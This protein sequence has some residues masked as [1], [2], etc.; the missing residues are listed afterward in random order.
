[1]RLRAR[2]ARLERRDPPR[3]P[4]GRE[5]P[6]EIWLT[7]NGRGD[8]PGRYPRLGSSAVLVIYDA[9]E[10]ASLSAADA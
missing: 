7:D 10:Q 5:P 8:P 1:M 6:F 9:D 4:Q 3:G 2:L